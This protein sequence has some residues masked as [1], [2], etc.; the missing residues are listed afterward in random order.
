MGIAALPSGAP[1][2]LA[3]RY[4]SHTIQYRLN[5]RKGSFKGRLLWGLLF[6]LIVHLLHWPS[7]MTVPCR[8]NMQKVS[9]KGRL[10]WILLFCLLMHLLQWSSDIMTCHADRTWKTVLRIYDLLLRK[11]IRGSEP[12]GLFDPD[13][14]PD[15]TPFFSDM[16][17]AKNIF[18]QFFSHNLPTVLKFI[19]FLKLLFYFASITVFQSPQRL[20]EKREGSESISLTTKFWS[21]RL[22]QA[23]QDP[24]H[25][26]KRFLLK[27]D[28]C[29]GFLFCLPYHCY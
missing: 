3:F 9:F 17:E 15:P 18:I 12:L 4:R 24:Q 10:F 20:Y 2:A 29:G 16:K 25:W 22:K 8:H 6:C 26:W 23:N 5:R 11:W 1:A 7:D 19:I 14:T 13:P 21:G 28:S 27:G